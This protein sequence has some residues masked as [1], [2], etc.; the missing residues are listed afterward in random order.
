[1]ELSN[2]SPDEI[3]QIFKNHVPR[4]EGAYRYHSVMVLLFNID[5]ELNMLFNKRASTLNY[6]PGEICFPG[7]KAEEGETPLETAYREV[8]EELG[9]KKENIR[10]LGQPD[11]IITHSGFIIMPFLGYVEGLRVEQ[12][13]YSTD[14]VES[15]FTVPLNFFKNHSPKAS[16]LHLSPHIEDD[17]PVEMIPNGKEYK[18]ASAKVLELFYQYKEFIIWGITARIARNVCSIIEKEE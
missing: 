9:I 18:F 13:K 16:Y 1:M 14:E 10:I 15:I 3:I 4:P 5:G 2:A 17:F 6:Q 11:F 12:I 8:Y 7:G